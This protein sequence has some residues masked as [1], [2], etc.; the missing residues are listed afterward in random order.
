MSKQLIGALLAILLVAM[1][2]FFYQRQMQPSSEQQAA[3]QE[4]LANCQYDAGF[5]RYMAAQAAAME[6]G[7]VIISNS[8]IEGMVAKSETRMVGSNMSSESYLG[9]KLQSRM[10]M[11]DGVTYM[12]DLQ[13]QAWYALPE[14]ETTVD[15]TADFDLSDTYEFDERM[16]VNK[17][18]QETCGSLT[19]DKYEVTYLPAEGEEVGEEVE[20][21]TYIYVDTKEY[22]A[23]KIEMVFA[24]GSSVLE[25]RYEA[26]SIAKPSPI[27]DMPSFTIP[28]AAG[29]DGA[30]A[31]EM[32]SQEEIEQMM[33]QYGLDGG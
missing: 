5:C 30:A 19:C 15:T 16:I 29:A 10:I 11:F 3:L 7:V 17:V 18:G 14:A 4:M 28:A 2:V 27:K 22:L 6:R 23:R 31:G 33:L 26:V 12:Q 21:H 1:G 9:D 25:Y 13:D 20:M 8:Q 32:P 24:A